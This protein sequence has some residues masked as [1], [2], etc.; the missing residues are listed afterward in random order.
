MLFVNC[1]VCGQTINYF[2]LAVGNEWK[3]KAPDKDYQ[4][5]QIVTG[6]DN[7]YEAFYIT[8]VSKLGTTFPLTSETLL[9]NRGGDLIQLGV[10]GFNSD[11]KLSSC[12]ILSKE[13]N[14][15]KEWYNTCDGDHEKVVADTL[16]VSVTAGI[17]NHVLKI[18]RRTKLKDKAI[19]IEYYAPNIGLIKKSIYDLEKNIESIFLELVEYHI[20]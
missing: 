1:L 13:L 3:Y 17:F 20:N 8:H 2:P 10:M 16:T 6:Y 18:E 9:E 12:L 7:Y 4:I 19:M 11:W 14:I 5:K 15:G